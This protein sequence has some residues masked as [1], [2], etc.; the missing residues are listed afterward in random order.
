MKKTIINPIEFDYIDQYEDEFSDFD[1][2]DLECGLLVAPFG[3]MDKTVP[4]GIVWVE[5]G[6]W[7]GLMYAIYNHSSHTFKYFD[8][9]KDTITYIE[10]MYEE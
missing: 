2:Q 9:E 6:H 4:V 10:K 3:D 1:C 7:G 5:G 8:N